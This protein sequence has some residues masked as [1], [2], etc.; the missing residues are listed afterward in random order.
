MLKEIEFSSK[1]ENSDIVEKDIKECKQLFLQ[2]Q[3][4]IK[5]SKL[6][7]IVLVEGFGTSGKG[8]LIGDLIDDIDPRFYNVVSMKTPSQDEKRK[9]FL[10]R[11]FTNIPPEG[12]FLFID[13]GWMDET[14]KDMRHGRL[15]KEGY[16]KRIES[17]N[18]FERLLVQNGYIV[19]KC[20]LHIPKEVQKKRI[21]KLSS[22]EDTSWRISENDIWQNNNYNLAYKYFDEYLEDTNTSYA[23]WN[24]INA[25]YKKETYLNVY[26]RLIKAVEDGLINKDSKLDFTNYKARNFSL[27]PISAIS[28]LQLADKVIDEKHYKKELLK[29]QEK[30]KDIHNKLYLKKIPMVI[31]YEGMDAS[32][33][34]GN[35]KRLTKMLDPRGF[36][37]IPIAAPQKNELA[38]QYLWRF[39]NNI[40]KTGHIAIF[41]RSWYGRV[42]VERVEGFCDEREW[43][44]AYEE[45]NEFEQE[46]IDWGAIV[47]KFWVH[48]DSDTQLERFTERQNTPDKQWKITDEDWRNRAKWDEY[49][50]AVDDML[51]NTNTK[52]VPWH[53][54]E[55]VNK[56]YARM[57]VLNLVIDASEAALKNS[58]N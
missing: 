24:I 30:L 20:F 46:L 4:K 19:F 22:N 42:L 16:K 2:Q 28:E 27:R 47:L 13:S 21:A 36:E 14:V 39:W 29:C 12:K 17:I 18:S 51:Q 38:R 57:K 52:K 55:S 48:I 58:D 37:V 15:S 33:K 9:P 5:D 41:D 56:E 11:Y 8:R 45:I 3:S 10:W 25:K 7:I 40:P 49:V 43:G 35:I 26:K 53:I 50:E 31:V 44:R 1:K 54:I 6:P 23:P 34:G 32:G